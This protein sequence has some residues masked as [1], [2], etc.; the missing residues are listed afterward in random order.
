MRAAERIKATIAAANLSHDEF[1]ALAKITR[2]SLHK[3]LKPNVFLADFEGGI[4]CIDVSKKVWKLCEEGRF[5]L[6]REGRTLEG[7]RELLKSVT[8]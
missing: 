7:L 4:R 8:L 3:Y 6:E 2:Q 1:S 5:P